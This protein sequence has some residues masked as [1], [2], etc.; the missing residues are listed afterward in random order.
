MGLERTAPVQMRMAAL[1]Q[2]ETNEGV[3][4]GEQNFPIASGGRV[5]QIFENLQLPAALGFDFSDMWKPRMARAET[6][7]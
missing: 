2:D 3:V 4:K 6:E 7:A 1:I 5:C